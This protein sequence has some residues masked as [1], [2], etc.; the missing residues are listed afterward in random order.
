MYLINELKCFRFI[1]ELEIS[2]ESHNQFMNSLIIYK[3]F[4][5]KPLEF[6]SYK[7]CIRLN[8]H[9]ANFDPALLFIITDLIVDN[10]LA[11]P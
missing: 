2:G 11:V 4:S 6:K 3:I 5:N 7:I 10:S 8:L 1:Y 9:K